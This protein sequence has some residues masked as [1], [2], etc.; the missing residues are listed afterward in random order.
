MKK[1][2][3]IDKS[4]NTS[5]EF[6]VQP[7][8]DEV[9]HFGEKLD[10]Y[11]KELLTEGVLRQIRKETETNNMKKK[12]K[13]WQ[14]VAACLGV[15]F[16]VPSS[17]FAAVEISHYFRSQVSVEDYQMKVDIHKKNEQ[18]TTKAPEKYIKLKAN[19]G[20][21]YKIDKEDSGLCTFTHKDGFDAGK[22][23]W[24]EIIK[25]D[26]KKDTIYTTYDNEVVE[27]LKVNGHEAVYFKTNE[28]VGTEYAEKYDTCYGQH[29]LV[30]YDEYGY[31]VQFNSMNKL[32]KNELVKLAENVSVTVT[33]KDSASGYT[34]LSEYMK[35]PIS[36][37]VELT[38]R[39]DEK[40]D[41]PVCKIGE[42]L[43]HE[44]FSIQIDNV[45]LLDSVNSLKLSSFKIED[46][47]G[48]WDEN[49]NLKSYKRE[50]LQTGNGKNKPEKKVESR[51]V[52]KPKLVYVTMNI[53]NNSKEKN[54]FCLPD[55]CFTSKKNGEYYLTNIY[56]NSNR[57]GTVEDA[58]IDHM[59]CYFEETAGGKSFWIQELSAGEERTFNFAYFVDEDMT[60]KMLLRIDNGSD[61]DKDMKYIDISR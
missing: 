45:K 28:I 2:I 39:K 48:L 15:A 34:L 8:K 30:F 7:S 20:S 27:N 47:S 19:F 10:G 54:T 25:V 13:H 58:F 35:N 57:P 3:N 61:S 1:R 33:D 56:D 22:D 38:P 44:Q 36:A 12:W 29:L 43:E 50:N 40:I 11:E 4:E 21:A 17:V 37:N 14:V 6:F 46:G 60:D 41:A 32:E 5:T 59:P 16:L 55:V 52:I 9:Y 24:Y 31:I 51:E 26:G 49:G 53:K 18:S 23:F 42:R